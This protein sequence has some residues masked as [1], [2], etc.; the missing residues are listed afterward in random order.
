MKISKT[1]GCHPVIPSSRHPVI[2]SSRYPVIP[3]SCHPVIPSSRHPVILEEAQQ[4]FRHEAVRGVCDTGRYRCPYYVWGDGPVLVFIPGISDDARSFLLPI[5]LLSRYFRCVAYDLP[6]GASDGAR[7]SDYRHE[8]YVADL[9]A[10]LDQVGAR[11]SY[12]YGASFGSTIALAA[13]HA[14]P[15][16]L[17]RAVLQGGFARRRLAPAE[18]LLARFARY[19]TG[20]MRRLPFRAALL[21]HSHFAPFAERGP[22]VW[23]FFLGR[24]GSPPL[25]TVARRALVVNQIDLRRLLPAIKRPVLLVCGDRDPLVNRA[26]E[27]ELLRGLPEVS[28]VELPD[29]GHVPQF[30]HP[31][32]LADVVYRFLTPLP[33]AH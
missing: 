24:W 6:A 3:S 14:R 20:P 1:R 25:A 19:W 30:S 31:E 13:L 32:M 5:A 22:E 28:R 29:C 23:E 11:Q 4:R 9:F 26:C 12:L 18:I 27:L 15:E 10:L 33:C 7:L 16:R 2:P 21:R 8:D 17:P